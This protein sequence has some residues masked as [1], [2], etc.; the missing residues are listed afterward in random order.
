MTG[1]VPQRRDILSKTKTS[2]QAMLQY[3]KRCKIRIFFILVGLFFNCDTSTT[4]YTL[5]VKH[6]CNAALNSKIFFIDR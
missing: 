3:Y 6:F 1:A 5:V 4:D 2:I